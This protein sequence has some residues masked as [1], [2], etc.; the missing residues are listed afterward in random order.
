MLASKNAPGVFSLARYS[1]GSGDGAGRSRPWRIAAGRQ[2][3]R[4]PDKQPRDVVGFLEALEVVGMVSS[5]GLASASVVCR[6]GVFS[7]ENLPEVASLEPTTSSRT[8]KTT[9]VPESDALPGVSGQSLA[10]N[11]ACWTV[12]PLC[13]VAACGVAIRKLRFPKKL[14]DSVE[15]YGPSI[16]PRLLEVGELLDRN[17]REVRAL[18]DQVSRVRLKLRLIHKDLGTA[19][20]GLTS[21]SLRQGGGLLD[22]V[23]RVEFLQDRARDHDEVLLKMQ[24]A[25]S[26]QFKALV[27]A[28]KKVQAECMELEKLHRNGAEADAQAGVE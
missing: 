3:V 12:V 23:K 27:Q 19:L 17:D 9:S 18:E 1:K 13:V 4:P 11:L 28:V 26:R 20:E 16:G 7:G 25:S 2:D 8:G 22:V 15:K 10:S 5:V 6:T 24:D 14:D 21:E